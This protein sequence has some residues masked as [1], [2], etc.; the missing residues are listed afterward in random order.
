M[1]GLRESVHEYFQVI[2]SSRCQKSN[3]MIILFYDLKKECPTL[4]YCKW[5][6]SNFVLK[7][8]WFHVALFLNKQLISN[9]NNVIDS[10]TF[11]SCCMKYE[12]NRDLLFWC[13]LEDYTS[14]TDS[15]IR[16]LSLSRLINSQ[17]LSAFYFCCCTQVTETSF[18]HRTNQNIN[19][20]DS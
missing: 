14:Q 20:I 19:L 2:H 7:F 11:K 4:N 12:L 6:G 9:M 10:K 15:P 8:G 5:L 1:Y 18:G 13:V 17:A 3:F 16:P